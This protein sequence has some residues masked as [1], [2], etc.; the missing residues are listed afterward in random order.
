MS[1]PSWL[2]SYKNI[3]IW[4]NDELSFCIYKKHNEN[5]QSKYKILSVYALISIQT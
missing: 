4:Q 1:Y 2:I 3:K 5:R